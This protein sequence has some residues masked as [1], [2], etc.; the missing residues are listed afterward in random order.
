MNFFRIKPWWSRF[1]APSRS[2]R[3]QQRRWVQH[4]L[5]LYRSFLALAVIGALTYLS[6]YQRPYNIPKLR[7]GNVAPETIR[8]PFLFHV[9]KSEEE[10][11]AEL[12]KA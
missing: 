1:K 6:P 3:V 2:G 7:I 11:A 9:F 4:G 12:R 10:L 5:W 8:A